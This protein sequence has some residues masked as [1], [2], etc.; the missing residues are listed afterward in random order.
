MVG[1][2]MIVTAMVLI[3]ALGLCLSIYNGRIGTAIEPGH[4]SGTAIVRKEGPVIFYTVVILIA[5]TL[6]LFAWYAIRLWRL[7]FKR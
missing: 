2:A 4:P 3:G 5:G 7:I 1:W 6:V